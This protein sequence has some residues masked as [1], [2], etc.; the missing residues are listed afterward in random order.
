MVEKTQP[1]VSILMGIYNCAETLVEAVDSIR[2]QTFDSWELIMCDD[3]STDSTAAVAKS[4]TDK[5]QRI[6]LFSNSYNLGLAQTLDRCAALARGE[7][8]GRMDGDDVSEPD[9]LQKLVQA[10]DKHPEIAVVSSWMSRFDDSGE[11][12]MTR[13][14]PFPTSR[15]FLSGSPICHAACMIR[16]ESFKAAGGYG[17]EPWIIRAEDYHLWFKMY[18]LGFRAMNLQESLYRMRDDRSAQARRTLCS[19]LNETRVRWNGFGL[20]GFPFWKRIWAIRPIVVFLVPAFLY[21]YLRKCR[22]GDK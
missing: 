15:D 3:G 9:R 1:R 4:L 12:G 22:L 10:L 14:K 13:S 2:S 7:Y 11:W 6:R 17:S 20:L 18:T 5:D 21:R 19:R 8:L 16:R